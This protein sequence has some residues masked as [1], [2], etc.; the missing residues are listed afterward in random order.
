MAPMSGP[1]PVELVIHDVTPVQSAIQLQQQGVAP[2]MIHSENRGT[3]E[4]VPATIRCRV[5]GLTLEAVSMEGPRMPERE[6]GNDVATG[7]VTVPRP[8]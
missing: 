6:P 3:A 7:A 4:R 8:R 5:A 1:P 2:I